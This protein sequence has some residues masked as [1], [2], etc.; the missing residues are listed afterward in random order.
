M[1]DEVCV[2]KR[3]REE[4]GGRE[5]AREDCEVGLCASRYYGCIKHKRTHECVCNSFMYVRLEHAV[6][7]TI[8]S[9]AHTHS[10]ARAR[11]H[12]SLSHTHS[13]LYPGKAA[14]G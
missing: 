3:E 5:G 2:R 9:R 7:V 1:A 6:Y 8:H 11:E 12:A 4:E 14:G 13:T 10:R